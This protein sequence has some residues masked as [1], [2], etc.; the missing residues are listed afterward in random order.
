MSRTV[1][2][3][4]WLAGPGWPLPAELPPLADLAPAEGRGARLAALRD[5]IALAEAVPFASRLARVPAAERVGWVEL[6]RVVV[7]GPA[8]PV[9]ALRCVRGAWEPVSA[10]PCPAPSPGTR[11]SRAR[12]RAVPATP[13]RAPG[14]S[15]AG[16]RLPLSPGAAAVLS[17]ARLRLGLARKA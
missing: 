16:I 5:R 3:L 10:A 13:L 9:L 2:P 1:M 11:P 12:S 6:D 7:I 14:S 4:V 17:T 8:G 15:T